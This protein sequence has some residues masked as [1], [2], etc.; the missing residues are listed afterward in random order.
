VAIS[1]AAHQK[2][3]VGNNEINEKSTLLATILN[4]KRK[5]TS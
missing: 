2:L 1:E 5:I 3:F 4:L